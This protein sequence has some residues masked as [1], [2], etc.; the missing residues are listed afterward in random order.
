MGMGMGMGMAPAAMPVVPAM[1]APAPDLQSLNIPLSS[2]QPSNL[3]PLT[4][5]DKNGL[6]ITIHLA[7]D[8]P[9]PT[10][11]VMVVSIVNSSPVTCSN[12]QFLAAVPKTLQVKLQPAS[13]STLQAVLPG[14][15]QSAVSQVML[16]ANPTK[17]AVRVRFKLTYTANGQEVTE[18]GECG[19]FPQ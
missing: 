4:P 18:S 7:R 17:A 5:F 15:P 2:I 11:Q 14:Q 6:R 10:I 16:I 19:N 8:S 9:H 13:G 3:A 12:V 1:S